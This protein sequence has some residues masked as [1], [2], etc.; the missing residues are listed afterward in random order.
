MKTLLDGRREAV[1]RLDMVYERGVTPN[2]GRVEDDQKRS[3]WWLFFICYVGVPRHTAVSVRE[4]AFKLAIAT[5]A[6]HEVDFGVAFGGTTRLQSCF[7]QQYFLLTPGWSRDM[8]SL[9]EYGVF[10]N[11]HQSQEPSG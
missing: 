9:D 6:I 11:M 10:Q 3:S 7:C 4:E 2:F 8:N 1:V 5:I